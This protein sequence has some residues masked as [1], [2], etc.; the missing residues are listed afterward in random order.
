MS[1]W[2]RPV[3]IIL[4]LFSLLPFAVMAQEEKEDALELYRQGN[5]ARSVEICLQEL[6]ERGADQVRQRMDSYTVLGWSYLRLGRYPQALESALKARNEVR[7]DERIIEIQGEALYFLGRNT[8]A[9]TIFEEY[10]GVNPTGARIATVYYF[11]G[12]IFLRLAEYHHAD[13]AFATALHH[14]PQVARWWSRLGYAREQ[15]DDGVGAETAYRK[16]LELQPSLEDARA[17]LERVGT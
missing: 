6:E 16:A 17:G 2:N 15:L 5:Y 14:S 12:E 8:E 11:M 10:V 13:V 7:Y 9:L 1:Q 4:A 3:L